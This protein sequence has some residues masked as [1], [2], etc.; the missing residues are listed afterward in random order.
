MFNEFGFHR[1][2]DAI[3]DLNLPYGIFK[4]RPFDHEIEWVDGT[5]SGGRTPTMI[6]GTLS[7]E[8][9]AK[10]Y[11]WHPGVFK[12][13]NFDMRVLH[14]EWGGM[15]LN[16][17]AKFYK[18][19]E[20]PSFEGTAF[21]RPVLDTKSF[22]GQLINGD[23]FEKWRNDLFALRDEFTTVDLNTEVMVASPKQ[24]TDEARFFVVN[25]EVVA[26]SMYR[27]DGRVMYRAISTNVPLYQPMWDFAD[28]MVRGDE[29]RPH[30]AY[31]MDVA[32]IAPGHTWDKFRVIEVNCINSAGFYD[33]DMRAVVRALEGL[34]PWP[35]QW[36]VVDKDGYKAQPW[37][38]VL[39]DRDLDAW[40]IANGYGHVI[41]GRA[42]SSIG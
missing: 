25:R 26:G 31:V 14:R 35:E 17:D 34:H 38:K 21:I 39:D 13:E 41:E 42:A 37:E 27:I 7:V 3:K 15:M 23:E 18:L 5:I 36:K 2:V 32:R 33:C 10:A 20:V 24:M 40:R 8:R 29:W 9:A 1:L 6:W 11:G 28:S 22:A 4:L 30:E 19:G 12:N 16:A